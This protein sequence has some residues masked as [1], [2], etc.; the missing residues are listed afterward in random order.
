MTRV[1]KITVGAAALVAA[2]TL[3]GCGE[4]QQFASDSVT[5]PAPTQT[6][7][8]DSHVSDWANIDDITYVGHQAKDSLE[9]YLAKDKPYEEW[10]KTVSPTLSDEGQRKFEYTDPVNIPGSKVTGQAKLMSD[11]NWTLT[12][13]IDT[14]GG[15][16]R[17]DM[18]QINDAGDWRVNYFHPPEGQNS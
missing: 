10:W 3:S 13:G 15:Q 4:S 11:E 5:K 12:Y 17:V 6:V 1:L 2:L 16:Y 9:L 14:D 18:V 8:E 7:A